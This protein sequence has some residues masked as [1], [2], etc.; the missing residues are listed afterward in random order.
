VLRG[1]PGPDFLADYDGG[2]LLLAGTGDDRAVLG[3]GRV[4][5]SRLFLGPGDDEVVVQDDGLLDVVDCGPGR[6]IA[7]WVDTRDAA[8]QYVGCEEVREYLGA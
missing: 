3:S 1:G 5:G 6:D 2:D 7:E 4:G 8:D